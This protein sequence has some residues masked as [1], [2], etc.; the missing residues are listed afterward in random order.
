MSRSQATS[1]GRKISAIALASLGAVAAVVITGCS[2]G[3]GKA[4]DEDHGS[5]VAQ[6]CGGFV[7]EAPTEAALEVVMGTE[8]FTD[9]LSEPERALEALR[10]AARTEQADVS[11]TQAIPYCWLLSAGGGKQDLR[12]ELRTAAEAPAPD[13]RLGDQVSSFTS[14]ERAFASVSRG[15]VYFN[16]RLGAP[17]HEILVDTTVRG[18]AGSQEPGRDHRTRLITLANAAAR[19]VSAALGCEGDRLAPG[20]PAPAASTSGGAGR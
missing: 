11:R 13:P 6:V 7:E 18:P 3:S 1:R 17:G 16:C 20:V 19:H 2:R 14:G 5:A 8:R 15:K 9:D 4:A 12:V 10:E